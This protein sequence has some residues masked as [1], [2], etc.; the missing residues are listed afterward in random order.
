[1]I[2]VGR[3]FCGGRNTLDY[4]STNVKAM[5]IYMLQEMP[6]VIIQQQYLQIGIM[7]PHFTQDFKI[8]SM[9]VT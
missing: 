7:I 3:T 8:I 6:V 1:M 2:F 9:L 4:T 5:M